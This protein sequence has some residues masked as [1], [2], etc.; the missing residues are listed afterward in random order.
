[1]ITISRQMGSGGSYI[2]R[3]LSERLGIR[4]VDRD[5]LRSASE[6]LGQDEEQIESREERASG[7]LSDLLR[8][9]IQGSPEAA[10][11]PPP[12]RPVYDREL[13]EA[14]A[15]VIRRIAD[16]WDSVIVGRGGFHVLKE[17]PGLISVFLHAPE[18]FRLKR[19]M[20]VYDISDPSEAADLIRDS[21][22][23]RKRF[24]KAFAGVEWTDARCYRL[25]I[26]TAFAGFD[27]AEE[28]ILKLVEQVKVNRPR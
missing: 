19:I 14:E 5:V 16:A 20:Q 6:Y 21:D 11:V 15:L 10:Y 27:A 22:R 2:G 7:F 12:L 1:L 17:R 26:N 9:F 28:M 4:Y 3:R 23:K 25:C 24:I 18:Q 8:G 13:F